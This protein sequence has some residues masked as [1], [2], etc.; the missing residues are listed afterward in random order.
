[1]HSFEQRNICVGPFV[2]DW[3]EVVLTSARRRIARD[4]VVVVTHATHFE[5]AGMPTPTSAE[6]LAASAKPGSAPS[7]VLFARR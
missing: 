4:E 3:N 6:A 1:M 5:I 7:P 2:G